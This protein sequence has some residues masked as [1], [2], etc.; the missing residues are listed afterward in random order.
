MIPHLKELGETIENKAKNKAKGK[1]SL[2]GYHG[3][4][5]II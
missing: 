2:P 4:R 1:L 5:L 3:N